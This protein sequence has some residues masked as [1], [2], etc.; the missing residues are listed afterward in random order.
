MHHSRSRFRSL[1][2]LAPRSG[3]TTSASLALAAGM[4]LLCSCRSLDSVS[5]VWQE[6]AAVVPDASSPAP[7]EVVDAATLERGGDPAPIQPAQHVQAAPV[8]AAPVQAAP[9]QAAPV[10][11]APVQGA[12]V[13]GAPVQGAPV[14]AAPGPVPGLPLQAMPM[15]QGVPAGAYPATAYPATAYPAASGYPTAGGCACHPSQAGGLP[16]FSVSGTVS[17]QFGHSPNAG[18]VMP[19]QT[20]GCV[21]GCAPMPCGPVE[22]LAPCW[23]EDEYIFDGGDRF[24]EVTVA[25]NWT[26]NGLDQEDTVIHYDTVAGR[27]EV[28]PSNRVCI[29]APRFA[30]VRKVDGITQLMRQQPTAGVDLPLRLASQDDRRGPN[31]VTQP[32][33]PGRNLKIRGTDILQEDTYGRAIENAQKPLATLENLLAFE[34]FEIIRRGVFDNTEKARLAERLEAAEV[35]SLNK[36][37]QVV[38]DNQ[39]ASEAKRGVLPEE[40]VLYEMPPGKPRVRIIKLASKKE[41]RPGEIV[42]FTLRFDNIGDQVV[43]NVTIIDNLTTRLEYVDGSQSCTRKADFVTAANEGETLILRWEITDPLKVGEGGVIRFK[44]RVR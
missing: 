1:R 25:R 30:A 40:G 33:Q 21:G 27:R 3:W 6:A 9:V 12:P 28:R 32:L 14:Q 20:P 36:Q 19:S 39:H 23:P 37:V 42:D 7:A 4:V 29:Y 26:V 13:Q 16:P 17:S 24:A 34:D 22:V 8:Q 10:Q 31:A 15:P 44:C 5:G 2:V 43:G 11:A 38:V 41:A 18:Y 35:W